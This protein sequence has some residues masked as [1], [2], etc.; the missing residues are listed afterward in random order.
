MDKFFNGLT[1]KIYTPLWNKYRPAILQL[2]V[3]SAEGPQEYKLFGHEFLSAN[4]KER[5]TFTFTL[6]A[7]RG[8]ATNNIKKSVI[9]QDLLSVLETS[10]K[11]LELMDSG[12]YEFRLD[13]K[14]IL[15]IEK[16]EVK[17]IGAPEEKVE[18]EQ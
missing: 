5:G 3:S 8:K 4:P 17:T 18:S 14:F 6:Q 13:K 16:L 10:K 11:A 12:T 9:A 2:M 15:H 1:P 7:H